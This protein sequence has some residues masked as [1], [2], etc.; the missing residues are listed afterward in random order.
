MNDTVNSDASGYGPDFSL[1]KNYKV[2]PEKTIPTY[3]VG[4]FESK[5]SKDKLDQFS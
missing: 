3:Q 5:E 1:K 4:K 2:F